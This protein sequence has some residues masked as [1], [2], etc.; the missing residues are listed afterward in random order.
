MTRLHPLLVVALACAA[1][2]TGNNNLDTTGASTVGVATGAS[3]GG[4]TA[5]GTTGGA[6]GGGGTTGGTTGRI[7]TGTCAAGLKPE[8]LV[9][10]LS[11]FPCG[12]P[13][14]CVDDPAYGGAVCEAVC[15][16]S[17]Q[18]DSPFTTCVGGHC[19]L[20]ACGITPVGDSAGGVFNATCNA[21]GSDDGTCLPQ[22]VFLPDG[23]FGASWGLCVQGGTDDGGC[24]ADAGRGGGAGTLCPAGS[25]CASEFVGCAPAC[26]PTVA[27]SCDGGSCAALPG[28]TSAQ[29]G[30][31]GALRGTTTCGE[32]PPGPYGLMVGETVPWTFQDLGYWD[33]TG[34]WLADGGLPDPPPN[35]FFELLSCARL[36]GSHHLL[37]QLTSTS[38]NHSQGQAVALSRDLIGPDQY[39][40]AAG[41]QVMQILEEGQ[42]GFPPTESDLAAWAANNGVG[43]TLALDSSQLLLPLVDASGGWPVTL[44]IDLDTMQVLSSRS[45]L[46]DLG[47]IV[48]DFGQYLVDGG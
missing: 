31:C 41:G 39:W 8:E 42:Q 3:S 12:C 24:Q 37:L 19:Q 32:Y 20:N 28:A 22:G 26:D 36:D 1:C 38:D 17:V 10:C 34:A 6:T 33:P 29:A 4:G 43:F 16:P 27:N 40:L 30:Y 9:P 13:L 11:A 46:G 23:G 45:Y 14:E 5:G 35:P 44:I 21:A 48:A 15:T 2:S 47:Q 18:C 25:V 7:M